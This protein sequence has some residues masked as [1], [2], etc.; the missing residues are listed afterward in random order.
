MTE[1]RGWVPAMLLALPL[2]GFCTLPLRAADKDLLD[3]VKGRMKI[4]A[5]RIEK[6]FAAERSA[7][8]KLVRSESPRLLAATEK[9]QTL[10]SMVQADTSLEPKRREVL[11]VTLKFDLGKVREIA[12]ANRRTTTKEIVARASRS[13]ARRATEDR[14]AMERR[15][16]SGDARSTIESRGRSIADE[17]NDRR[18]FNEGYNKTLSS[19]DKSAR[20]VSD[21]M[22]FP[23]DWVTKSQKRSPAQK[24]TEKEK[25]ILKALNTT[26]EADL[27]DDT[28]FEEALD[29]LKKKTGLDF[30]VDKRAMDEVGVTYKS[31]VKLKLKGTTRTVLKKLLAD[32]NLAY[33]IKSETVQITSQERAKSETTTRTYYV[34]DLAAVT[35]LRFGPLVSKALMIQNLNTLIN[36]ITQT[37]EP[38]SWQ[39]NNPDA[40]GTITFDPLTMSLIVKQTAEMHYMMGSSR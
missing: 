14:V 5:Q 17:R 28:T 37:I 22:T 11:I 7:A 2:L 33:F 40:V 25:A 13:D 31:P 15:P 36:T 3:D 18:K 39:V 20:P 12:D 35:D 1:M 19:V 23:R 34:G 26:I 21:N 8:Y 4:E 9:L 29:W 32:L 10:L 30:A 16:A 24:L 27:P 6:E 38:R